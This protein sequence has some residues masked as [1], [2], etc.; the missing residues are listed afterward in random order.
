MTPKEMARLMRAAHEVHEAS[1]SRARMRYGKTWDQA[2][3][4]ACPAEWAG[5][6]SLAMFG[7]YAESWEW[8][9]QAEKGQ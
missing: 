2:A 1:Y 9:E 6:V 5:L 7:G 3:R 4:E 8:I